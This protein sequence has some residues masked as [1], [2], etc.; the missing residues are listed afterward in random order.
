[1]PDLGLWS[2][3]LDAEVPL[4]LS[5]GGSPAR[6]MTSGSLWSTVGVLLPYLR[7]R[8]RPPSSSPALDADLCLWAGVSNLAC[9][10]ST[11]LTSLS[12]VL[13]RSLMGICCSWFCGLGW[14]CC[15]VG[16]DSSSSSSLFLLGLTSTCIPSEEVPSER[17][18]TS[19]LNALSGSI[20]LS[21]AA[22]CC[23]C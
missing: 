1:M 16:L 4:S 17:M 10:F 15:L 3:C 14:A 13:L 6:S 21:G 22:G 11:A 9:R 20:F 23:C 18:V 2:G 5:L 19:S 12:M 7:K 8:S